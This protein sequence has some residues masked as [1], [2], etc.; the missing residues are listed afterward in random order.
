VPVGVLAVFTKGEPVGANSLELRMRIDNKSAQAAD[1]ST[2]T[3]RYWYQDEGLAEPLIVDSNYVAIGASREGRVS[4]VK[5]VRSTGGAGADHYLEF[6]MAGILAAQGA[7]DATDQLTM[8]LS[9]HDAVYSGRADV[10][11]DY[12]YNAGA[13]GY[14][15]KI[16]LHSAGKVIW[17][18]PPDL[19]AMVTADSGMVIPDR[20]VS[21]PSLF[22]G[23]LLD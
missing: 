10:T 23:Q 4:G 2:V 11:N 5:V 7:K 21:V 13:I 17:G 3:L 19:A 14:N 18:T 8:M 6:S 9:V 22:W 12:S 1:L 16:T 20:P 15:D